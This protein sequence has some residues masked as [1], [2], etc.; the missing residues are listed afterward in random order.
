MVASDNQFALRELVK[1]YLRRARPQPDGHRLT[2]LGLANIIGLD[3]KELS[4]RLSGVR[5]KRLGAHEVKAIIGVLIECEAI[6]T[7]VQAER[8][9]ELAGIAILAA[10]WL[11]PPFDR[12]L[13][14]DAG[15]PASGPKRAPAGS[16]DL[17]LFRSRLREL[18]RRASPYDD[19]RSPTQRDLAD[20]IGLAPAELSRRLHAA[21]GSKLNNNDV[22][23]IVRTLVTWEAIETRAEAE[24]L[25]RL[26][27]AADFSAVEW[28]SPPLDLLTI[29][30]L[31]KP[32]PT[33]PHNLPRALTSFVGRGAEL[34]HGERLLI[35]RP[36]VAITGPGGIGKTRFAIELARQAL[37]RF[38]AGVYLVELAA[39]F[40]SPL[41]PQAVAETLGCLSGSKPF[42]EQLV[43]HLKSKV[44]LI[45]LDNCEQVSAAAASLAR[46][47]LSRCPGLTILATSRARLGVV[48]EVIFPLGP[49]ALPSARET[50]LTRLGKVE[51]VALFVARAADT[52]FDFHLTE[53][54]AHDVIEIVG[55]L[56]GIPLAIELTA[57]LVRS[58]S[59][60]QMA[61]RLAERL[62]LATSAELNLP[63]RQR[64]LHTSVAWSYELLSEAER[65]LLWRLAVFRGGWE[66]SAAE[67]ICGD[68]QASHEV[69]THLV[70][71]VNKSL[72][73]ATPLVDGEIRYRMLEVVRDFAAE[74]LRE[75]DEQEGLG[76]RH[77]QLYLAL[78]EQFAKVD[79]GSDLSRWRGRLERE[80]DNI[81]AALAWGRDHDHQLAAGLALNLDE[82]WTMRAYPKEAYQLFADIVELPGLDA[83]LRLRLLLWLTRVDDNG[84]DY[85][86]TNRYLEQGIA[87]ANNLADHK[88]LAYLCNRRGGHATIR[89]DMGMARRDYQ[90]ALEMALANGDKTLAANAL[91]NLAG[92]AM[93]QGDYAA[94]QRGNEQNLVF[95]L[96]IGDARLTAHT[97]L[98]IAHAAAAQSDYGVAAS[99]YEQALAIFRQLEHHKGIANVEYG[100]AEIA[101]ALGDYSLARER[102]EKVIRA[103]RERGYHVHLADALL[104][105]AEL[106]QVAGS[107][108]LAVAYSSEAAQILVPTGDK[109]ALAH[110]FSC[111]ARSRALATSD[112]YSATKLLALATRLL[113]EAS[114]QLLPYARALYVQTL[115]EAKASLATADFARAWAEGEAMSLDDIGEYLLRELTAATPAMV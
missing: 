15:V 10:A 87:L 55:R 110:A 72:V 49:L 46:E 106:E 8:L 6:T 85:I 38:P 104:G 22:R 107:A 53:Q 51:A 101:T 88:A 29:A 42:V 67:S 109:L 28:A 114:S 19:G 47:L 52:Q 78:S 65:R 57:P 54:N 2:Q 102:Y 80:L 59:L 39:I 23:A 26:A 32:S 40:D 43:A 37:P 4:K 63:P 89:G 93:D 21:P 95:R 75:A 70:G 74:R 94:A 103:M 27:A 41:V 81:R 33:P 99:R 45:L 16:P 24:E 1:E 69:L 73:E 14:V 64:T 35:S 112:W 5:G 7:T 111:M 17:I 61:R 62:D 68:G 79:P 36:L 71:L 31:L 90:I 48:G 56:E 30:P 115:T 66:L 34:A 96:E 113:H 77:A 60:S 44:A 11:Q 97:L 20:S 83:P 108:M 98:F 86:V 3:A 82:F 91:N 9:F 50:D 25:L 105:L 12:L 18:Y 58:V 84:A 13:R 76:H 92:L 100:Q